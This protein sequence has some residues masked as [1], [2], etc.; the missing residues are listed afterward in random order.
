ML[1]LVLA[2]S[3]LELMP[4]ELTNHPAV[5]AHARQR[6]KP[7]SRILLDSNY[8]HAAMSNLAE[9][10]RRGRPDIVHLFLLTV[11]E[12]IANKQGHLRIFIHTRHDDLI[13]VS[14]QTRIM[15]SY[16]RFLGLIEQLF[17][18]HV[19][20]D[21]TQPLLTLQQHMSLKKVVDV[22]HADVVVACSKTGTPVVL[23]DYFKQ[24][25]QRKK[26]H[27]LCIIGGFPSGIFHADL[28]NIAT[29]TVSLYPEMLPA[30]T[31]AGEI[32]VN[33]ENVFL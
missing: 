33:Y 29:E 11:L 21:E 17:E 32:L 23:S 12:S 31:V 28:Q 15:R 9:G 1:T 26:H 19:V 6:G 14:P 8:H 10:R 18:R 20:P 7:A 30:W 13:T 16:E 2:E 5:I 27:I 3:E 22:V 24:L 25:K 4:V